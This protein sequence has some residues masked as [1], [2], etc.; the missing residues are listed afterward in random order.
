MNNS[1]SKEYQ[2]IKKMIKLNNYNMKISKPSDITSGT[3]LLE[4]AISKFEEELRNDDKDEN[5]YHLVIIGEYNREVCD[6]IQKLY[7]EAGWAKTICKTSS[8]KGERGGLTGLQ[9]WK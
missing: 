4:E 8:E 2:V 7:L 5:Y 3:S 6:E 1:N 9:L